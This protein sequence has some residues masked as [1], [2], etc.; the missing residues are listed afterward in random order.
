M[1]SAE[2]QGRTAPEGDRSE[3]GAYGRLLVV[4]G[5]DGSE[6]AFRALDAAQRLVL[7]RVGSIEVVYVAHL[8][9]GASMSSEA[10]VE[11]NKDF[12][13]AEA[14]FAKA[15]SAYME[16][17]EQRW[18]FQRRD[19]PIAHE[20]LAVADELR[21]DYGEEAT[22][23]IIVGSA[24]QTYHHVV[25]SVPVSLVRHAKYPIVVVP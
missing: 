23:I 10:Q 20:L 11:L 14:E 24:V 15:V 7:G 21:R 18:R 22:V 3:Q 13:D 6:P 9:V 25:G 19:G 5:F 1:S 16:G 8:S 2:S 4:V 17:H 12:D